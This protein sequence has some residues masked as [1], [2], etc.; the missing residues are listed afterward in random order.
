MV[1]DAAQGSPK[2][3]FH[4]RLGRVDGSAL[5][6]GTVVQIATVEQDNHLGRLPLLQDFF[7]FG[8][9]IWSVAAS[10]TVLDKI[11][12]NAVPA[13]FTLQ[14]GSHGLLIFYLQGLDMRI[15][16]KKNRR[17]AVPVEDYL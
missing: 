4:F 16:D 7:R 17:S 11:D 5:F 9:I 2:Q 14:K 15:S 6:R 3:S 8:G 12:G 10:P 1:T 13:Q